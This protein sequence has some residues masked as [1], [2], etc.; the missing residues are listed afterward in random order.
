MKYNKS[1]ILIKTENNY[2]LFDSNKRKILLINPLLYYI[3]SKVK[4]DEDVLSWIKNLK[5]DSNYIPEFGSYSKKDIEYNYNK[6]LFFKE[7]GFFSTT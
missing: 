7:N 2:Y 6:Y 5:N 4:N 3:A 1:T